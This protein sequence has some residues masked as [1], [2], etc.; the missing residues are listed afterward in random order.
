MRR[1]P[2][3]QVKEALSAATART[4]KYDKTALPSGFRLG[5]TRSAGR[6]FLDPSALPDFSLAAPWRAS[7]ALLPQHADHGGLG[8]LVDGV[9]SATGRS[10]EAPAAP[11]LQADA[12]PDRAATPD[13]PHGGAATPDTADSGGH[14]ASPGRRIYAGAGKLDEDFIALPDTDAGTEVQNEGTGAMQT[15]GLP[16]ATRLACASLTLAPFSPLCYVC[17]PV[18]PFH[19]PHFYL[20]AALSSFERRGPGGRSALADA[21]AG[22]AAPTKA[23]W[24]DHEHPWYEANQYVASQSL[25][26]HNEIVDLTSLLQPNA[27]EDAQRRTA[28]QS[29]E[30][31][32]RELF[33]T[34][35]L[36]VRRRRLCG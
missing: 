6:F 17:T 29:L 32:V 27:E 20:L 12:D 34:A 35:K 24:D 18:P 14:P 5:C 28:A 25:R 10:D 13:S 30:E 16:A 31:V 22:D 9:A 3:I 7:L 8:A 11:A 2:G 23:V 36:E 4:V 33:P 21:A 15:G 26:L 1:A 19:A